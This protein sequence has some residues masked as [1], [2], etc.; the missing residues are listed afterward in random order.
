MFFFQLMDQ[1]TG[2]VILEYDTEEAALVEL[3]E[4]AR[5]AGRDEI[6]GLALLKFQDGRP[7]LVAAGDELIAR[8]DTRDLGL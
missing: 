6:R 8:L 2:N 3:R 5:G 1:S 7:A 4:V